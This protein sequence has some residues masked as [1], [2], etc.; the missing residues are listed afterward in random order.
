VNYCE[1]SKSLPSFYQEI[2]GTLGSIPCKKWTDYFFLPSK[3]KSESQTT[4]PSCQND[5]SAHNFLPHPHN[6]DDPE[7]KS[8]RGLCF[9]F[10]KPLV[11]Y[12]QFSF[13]FLY[14]ISTY[15][16]A[17]GKILYR[18]RRHRILSVKNLTNLL[19]FFKQFMLSETN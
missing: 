14:D 6:S 19:S 3:N 8:S 13:A 16:G 12:G 7:E 5:I 15:E 4:L 1:Y 18:F 2:M 11:G 10:L 9:E 17:Q